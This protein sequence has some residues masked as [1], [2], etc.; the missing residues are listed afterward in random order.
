MEW[1]QQLDSWVPWFAFIGG[2]MGLIGWAVGLPAI[3][4]ILASVID[5]LAPILRMLTSAISGVAS[6][7]W[8]TICWPALKD[9]FDNW[10]TA[11]FVVG[12]AI[13]LVWAMDARMEIKMDAVVDQLSACQSEVT[14]LQ[15]AYKIKPGNDWFWPFW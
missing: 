12:T 3:I 10:R 13:L 8:H 11:I 2:S 9:I 6:W 15:R 5:V 1:L 7:I 14:K 4:R